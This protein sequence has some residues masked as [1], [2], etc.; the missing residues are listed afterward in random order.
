MPI[1]FAPKVGQILV[2]DYSLGGFRPPE[3]TKKR[4][5][6]VVSPAIKQRGRVATVVPL[7]TTPPQR[8][9]PFVVALSFD[10]PLSPR[11]NAATSW[12]KCDMIALSPSSGSTCCVA[13]ATLKPGAADMSF[14]R[15][16]MSN[17]RRSGLAFCQQSVIWVD[18]WAGHRHLSIVRSRFRP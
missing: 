10:P 12:A 15:S 16:T 3:M 4:P 1:R 6:I 11:F 9:L 7:S 14:A 8:P 17:S 2:C 18:I 13:R 5:V